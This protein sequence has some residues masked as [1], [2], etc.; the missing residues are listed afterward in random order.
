MGMKNGKR[1]ILHQKGDEEL[2]E[3]ENIAVTAQEAA[4]E[5][6]LT[7]SEIFEMPVAA[8]EDTMETLGIEPAELLDPEKLSELLLTVA[9][10]KGQEDLLTDAE[11]YG[12][13]RE[14]TELGNELREQVQSLPV[15]PQ[16]EMLKETG[17]METEH[18]EAIS[19]ESVN[20]KE[21]VIQQ[22]NVM[23]NDGSG[24]FGD[25]G[26][27]QN[28]GS[29]EPRTRREEPA[30]PVQSFA[31]TTPLQQMQEQIAEEI[32]VS[33]TSEMQGSDTENIMRQIVS[34]KCVAKQ[35]LAL[36]VL[37]Q[38]H[39]GIDSHDVFHEIKVSEGHSRFKRI[40]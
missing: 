29:D 34:L 17:S 30:A 38:L 36:V 35:I 23:Q 2:P 1:E 18:G 27:L 16:T 24:S 26:E 6:L 4:M 12:K 7:A 3:E 11:L 20:T 37:V 5:L 25:D 8:L 28:A 14:V 9:G 40:Y 21:P 19:A 32:T 31:E 22:N 10:A 13:F 39:L 33:E 15:I